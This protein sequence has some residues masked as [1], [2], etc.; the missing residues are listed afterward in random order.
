M[1]HLEFSRASVRLN[2]ESSRLEIRLMREMMVFLPSPIHNICT[3]DHIFQDV[4]DIQ[5]N[6]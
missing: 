6:L 5:H 4:V 3:Y 1:L 2:Q